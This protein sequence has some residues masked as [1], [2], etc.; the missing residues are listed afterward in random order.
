MPKKGEVMNDSEK[1]EI[2]QKCGFGGMDLTLIS[3]LKRPEWYGIQLTRDA[4]RTL[5]EVSKPE[6]KMEQ[7]A[8]IIEYCKRM[9]SI[10]SFEATNLLYIMSFTKRMS[11]IRRDPHYE[12]MQEWETD[13][14][15]KWLRYYIKERKEENAG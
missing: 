15:K 3:K 10:T 5:G 6:G 4:Q 7:N 11:E 9:G 2:L 1:L 14:H 8:R 12:V 13:G